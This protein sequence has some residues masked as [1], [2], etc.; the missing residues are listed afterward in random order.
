[1]LVP[2]AYCPDDP[3][4]FDEHVIIYVVG[5]SLCNVI[6][7]AGLSAMY[8]VAYHEHPPFPRAAMV[9]GLLSGGVWGIGLIGA[10]LA[11]LEPFGESI[12][13][14]LTQTSILIAG[15]WGIFYYGEITDTN[16]LLRFAGFA[17]VLLLGAVLLG[18]Y[19][20]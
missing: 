8:V 10:L 5:F 19:G 2:L 1:M 9:P 4:H 3:F 18:I 20:S 7:M 15:C 13:Y 16:K 17:S 11:T 6:V 14:P 12:G